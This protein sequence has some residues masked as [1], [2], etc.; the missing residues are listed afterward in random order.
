MHLLYVN[1]Y[2]FPLTLSFLFFILPK[3]F[4]GT[5]TID[6]QMC[7]QGAVYVSNT[8]TIHYVFLKF[9]P[10]HLTSFTELIKYHP[11]ISSFG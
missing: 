10:R 7:C 6:P 5:G 3:I 2:I 1:I 4:G 11:M 8:A 9:P